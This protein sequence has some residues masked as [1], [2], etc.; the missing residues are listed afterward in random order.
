M[1]PARV[2]RRPRFVL[3]A[4]CV[5]LATSCS[6][7]TTTTE[8]RSESVRNGSPQGKSEGRANATPMRPLPDECTARR[9]P[10]GDVTAFRIRY[11]RGFPAWSVN[12]R[13]ERNGRY[14]VEASAM[15]NGPGPSW[16]LRERGCLDAD[17]TDRI[18][19]T[20]AN[21]QPNE[22]EP[23]ISH[24]VESVDRAGTAETLPAGCAFPQTATMI[25]NALHVLKDIEQTPR[26]EACAA[27]APCSALLLAG[28]VPH[29]HQTYAEL[30]HHVR[31]LRDG[32]IVCRQRDERVQLRVHPD[33][34]TRAILRLAAV[35]PE[36]ITPDDSESFEPFETVTVVVGAGTRMS[37]RRA[38][39]VLRAA[40]AAWN[41]RA[42]RLPALCHVP[43]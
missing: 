41:E 28:T 27:N 36:G 9:G 15:P 42:T 17:T 34:A 24:C 32:S 40:R 30:T 13:F 1:N 5:A 8:A 39:D 6:S 22:T 35:V 19:A 14:D 31:I 16:R 25:A 11:D 4:L 18:F 38:P 33:D 3:V 20:L 23:E 43:R 10:S 37:S 21:R 2:H 26:G 12:G 7:T 29:V